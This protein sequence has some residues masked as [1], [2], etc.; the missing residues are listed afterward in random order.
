MSPEYIAA[1]RAYMRYHN[2]N[3]IYGLSSK[4]V[5]VRIVSVR[6]RRQVPFSNQS[7]CHSLGRPE[8]LI[9]EFRK[10]VFRLSLT[11]LDSTLVFPSLNSL[12]VPY[13]HCWFDDA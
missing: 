10:L 9:L 1:Q 13:P 12:D 2:M 6:K 5:L 7:C 11:L 8:L 4:C 3:P